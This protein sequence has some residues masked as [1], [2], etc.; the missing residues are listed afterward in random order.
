MAG[1]GAPHAPGC[2][3]GATIVG[4]TEAG[5]AG[6]GGAHVAATPAVWLLGVAGRTGG[7]DFFLLRRL[8]VLR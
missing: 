6:V 7:A 4:A 5:R 8:R 3:G 1:A 2:G